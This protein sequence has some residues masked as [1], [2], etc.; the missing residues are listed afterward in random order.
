MVVRKIY[1][2]TITTQHSGQIETF[3]ESFGE[4]LIDDNGR[5]ATHCGSRNSNAWVRGAYEYSAGKNYILFLFKKKSLAYITSFAVVSKL[6]L[7]HKDTDDYQQCGSF[8]DDDIGCAGVTIAVYED[9]QEMKGQTTFEM[10]LQLDCDN[11]KISYV[12]QRTKNKKE[13]NVDITKFPFPWQ[14][15]FYLFEIGDCVRLL[16]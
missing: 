10:E 15:Q 6:M 14:I 7:K 11:Q 16:P 2:S 12:N 3:G 1:V 9:F 5:L 4:I 8:S 13:M